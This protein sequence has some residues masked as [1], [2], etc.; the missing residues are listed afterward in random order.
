MFKKEAAAISLAVFG[1]EP[2]TIVSLGYIVK[3]DMHYGDH[4]RSYVSPNPLAEISRFTSSV[5][6]EIILG[7][8][9]NMSDTELSMRF[10]AIVKLINISHLLNRNPLLLSG[11]ETAKV[12]LSVHP[13]TPIVLN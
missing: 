6:D 4:T 1:F 3:S 8:K 9:S 10:N 12:I 7:A 13:E 11:G 5:A 2:D